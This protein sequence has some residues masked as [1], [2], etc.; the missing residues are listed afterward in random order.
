M[1]V[2]FFWG[3]LPA[4]CTTQFCYY[5][6]SDRGELAIDTFLSPLSKQRA[7]ALQHFDW[8]DL[9]AVTYFCLASQVSWR[10]TRLWTSRIL[11][12]RSGCWLWPRSYVPPS[13]TYQALANTHLS[14][15]TVGYKNGEA[16]ILGNH[17]FRFA[18]APGATPETLNHPTLLS[19]PCPSELY[20]NLFLT[21][22][23]CFIGTCMAL[24]H[25][26]WHRLPL[27]REHFYNCHEQFLRHGFQYGTAL[28]TTSQGTYW[29]Q[30]T[31]VLAGMLSGS[32]PMHKP[33]TRFFKWGVQTKVNDDIYTHDLFVICSYSLLVHA[34]LQHVGSWDWNKMNTFYE[35]IDNVMQ[36]H[37]KSRP[38]SSG[39]GGFFSHWWFTISDLQAYL[40]SSALESMVLATAITLFVLLFAT[41]S[42]TAT[43]IAT[44]SIAGVLASTMAV[45]VTMGWEM[46]IIE[47][48]CLAI[49]IG[50]SCDFVVH[51]AWAYVTSADAVD[52]EARESADR[53]V[54]CTTGEL[55]LKKLVV[56][57]RQQ[58]SLDAQ[59]LMYDSAE[60]FQANRS[61]MVTE[62][63][64]GIA[65]QPLLAK[66]QRQLTLQRIRFARTQ[67]AL[68][69]MGISVF[70]ASV[71]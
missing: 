56:Q 70:S 63:R 43:L 41:R 10:S 6:N 39:D 13:W 35:S 24:E 33:A 31:S 54:Q 52:H 25:V 42:L 27:S 3:I 30:N 66:K 28:S 19:A 20:R 22:Q 18:T 15:L 58:L 57:L 48:M 21:P 38:A 7:I 16:N 4:D 44:V 37:R 51:L 5:D 12:L 65:T 46:G 8:C 17:A 14:A 29:I 67:H 26:Y 32:M 68:G 69:T 59:S 64:D 11:L 1:T 36:K 49:L 23:F 9:G 53:R 71:T 47:S 34:C 50:I 61:A 55:E 45:L 2:D 40:A 62:L 60:S